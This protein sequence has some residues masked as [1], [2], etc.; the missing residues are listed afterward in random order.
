MVQVELEVHLQLT[1]LQL[2]EL[3]VEEQV[4]VVLLLQEQLLVVEEQVELQEVA[5]A[6]EQQGQLTLVVVEVQVEVQHHLLIMQEI[7][8]LEVQV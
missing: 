7:Q 1:E 8:E 5:E 4:E 2:K 6:M 3:V